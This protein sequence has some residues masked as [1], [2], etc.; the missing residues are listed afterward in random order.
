[1]ALYLQSKRYQTCYFL[2]KSVA[3][4]Q[5]P[6]M[7]FSFPFGQ[8]EEKKHLLLV[9]WPYMFLATRFFFLLCHF[10]NKDSQSCMLKNKHL[11]FPI[12]VKKKK[13]CTKDA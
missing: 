2:G 4:V 13:V 3:Y 9:T 6:M 10:L 7:T 8:Y 1:M 12:L 11:F 5:I